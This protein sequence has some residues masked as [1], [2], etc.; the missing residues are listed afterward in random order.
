MP[1]GS[2]AYTFAPGNAAYNG[3][4]N[5]SAAQPMQRG[6]ISQSSLNGYVPF[7][8][9]VSPQAEEQQEVKR[10]SK[11]FLFVIISLLIVLIIG[12]GLS[13]WLY[14]QNRDKATPTATPTFVITTPSTKPLF[15]DTFS[16]NATGWD[17]SS[18]PGKYE[19]SVG[20]GTMTLEDDDN[21]LLWEI[22][23]GKS[24][25]DF[26]LDVDAKLS[27]G[28][29]GNGYG[30]YIRGASTTASEIGT[31]YR[32]ELYGDGSFGVFKGALDASGN[33][34]N[35]QIGNYTINPAIL[36]EG[37]T[38]HLTLI[39]KGSSITFMVN[40]VTITT[41]SDTSYKGG[42][43]ALFVSNPSNLPPVAQATF[44]HLAIFPV[45]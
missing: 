17:L 28:D 16:N 25:A 42:L 44:S 34:I 2:S 29:P 11:I 36:K 45:P 14:L 38:N 41:Y 35:Q 10:G 39:A 43:V 4:L 24:F 33:T 32:F 12:G 31:Y 1:F 5:Q 9:T 13:G 37:Q 19:V 20:K 15:Q 23:P 21:K 3:L 7:A 27:K 30:V 8:P 6:P 22:L 40:G 26:R 18:M